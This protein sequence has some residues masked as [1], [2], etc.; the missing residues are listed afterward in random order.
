MVFQRSILDW[1]RGWGQSVMGICALSYI[2]VIDMKIGLSKRWR[3]LDAI[4]V[5]GVLA[6]TLANAQMNGNVSDA[7]VQWF[8][9]WKIRA[10]DCDVMK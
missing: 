1:R 9:C 5:S 2:Y 7:H 10:D 8:S 4:I 3:G 6:W